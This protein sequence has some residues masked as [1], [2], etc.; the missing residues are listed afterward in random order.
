MAEAVLVTLVAGPVG[1]FLGVLIA[2]VLVFLGGTML[3]AFACAVVTGL[4]FGWVP[5]R[6][7]TRLEPV[8][9]LGDWG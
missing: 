6:Q 2:A 5:T 9:E 1:V 8:V 3:L 4:A 7:V